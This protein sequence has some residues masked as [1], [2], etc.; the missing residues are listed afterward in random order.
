MAFFPLSL[1]SRF[2]SRAGIEEPCLPVLPSRT[3]RLGQRC[4]CFAFLFWVCRQVLV[5]RWGLIVGSMCNAGVVTGAEQEASLLPKKSP[6]HE[7][8]GGRRKQTG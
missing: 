4:P 8:A 2:K 1:G 3:H 6:Y 5:M 7:T